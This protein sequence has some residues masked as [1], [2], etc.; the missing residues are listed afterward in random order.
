MQ[1]LSY[2]GQRV[3][4]GQLIETVGII[5]AIAIATASGG[6]ISVLIAPLGTHTTL[7]WRTRRTEA[8]TLIEIAVGGVSASAVARRG[9]LTGTR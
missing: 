9:R 3:H 8:G 1:R 5:V 6:T 4:I 7:A 2:L